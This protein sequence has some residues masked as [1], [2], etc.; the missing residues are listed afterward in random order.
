MYHFDIIVGASPDLAT[1][2]EAPLESYV[3]AP[4]AEKESEAPEVKS[5]VTLFPNAVSA[6]HDPSVGLQVVDVCCTAGWAKSR[7]EMVA[8]VA[9]RRGELIARMSLSNSMMSKLLRGVDVCSEQDF[10]EV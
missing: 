1:V 4:C 3:G 2:N 10:S 5:I 8:M 9:S 7:A 6:G